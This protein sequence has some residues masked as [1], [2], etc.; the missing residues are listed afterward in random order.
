MERL[1]VLALV[2]MLVMGITASA[3]ASDWDV[4]GKV[5]TGVEGVRI[6]T[7]GRIDPIGKMI[8]VIQGGPR[9]TQEERCVYDYRGIGKGHCKREWVRHYVWKRKYIPQHREYSEKYGWIIVEAHYIRYRVE[10]GGHWED[11]YDRDDGLYRDRDRDTDR[12][13]DRDRD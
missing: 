8:E 13:R 5:L 1:K 12:E 6:V 3:F 4:A 7:G 9:R 11:R 2:G 10:E